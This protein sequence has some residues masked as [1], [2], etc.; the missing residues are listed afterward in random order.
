QW[1]G[2]GART[3]ASHN[4]IPC[5]LSP[6]TH[7]G[8]GDDPEH[9]SGTSISEGLSLIIS[10]RSGP[11]LGKAEDG[12]PSETVVLHSPFVNVNPTSIPW[13]LPVW[14]Q[15]TA[16]VFLPGWKRAFWESSR[17]TSR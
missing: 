15:E 14:R 16:R 8:V 2:D 13:P 17:S 9:R 11:V 4:S 5:L 6:N 7:R 1:I 12:G 10:E 3:I